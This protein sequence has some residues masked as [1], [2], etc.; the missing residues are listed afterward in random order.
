MSDDQTYAATG[1]E[2][3]QFIE[4]Y[5]RLES[6]KKDIVEDQKDV[7]SEA[8]ARGYDVKTL[9]RIIADRKKTTDQLQEEEAILDMYRSALGMAM[10]NMD[11]DDE[12]EQDQAA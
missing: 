4:R 7:M 3:R 11:T 2:L 6:E 8:K 10:N 9:K 5:E 12:D 1:G